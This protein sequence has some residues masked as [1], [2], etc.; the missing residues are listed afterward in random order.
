[1]GRFRAGVQY[2]DWR[3]TAAADS[4]FDLDL[5]EYLKMHGHMSNREVVVGVD[6]WVGENHGGPSVAPNITAFIAD[7]DSFDTVK[8]MIENT[9]DPL[10]FRRV[11]LEISFEEFFGLF[12]RFDIV[13]TRKGLELEGREYRE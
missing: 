6:V 10:D 8:A 1:M 7:R 11:D 5:A 3:G 9:P 4:A 2:D 13:I 12:K